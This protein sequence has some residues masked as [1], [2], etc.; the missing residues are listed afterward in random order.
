MD[1]VSYP[2]IP[3][4]PGAIWAEPWGRDKKYG[5]GRCLCVGDWE[6]SAVGYPDDLAEPG[7]IPIFGLA[8]QR[9][10]G[11]IDHPY[12]YMESNN[13]R[14]LT[15]ADADELIAVIGEIRDKLRRLS[16]SNSPG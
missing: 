4:P 16:D 7:H 12:I 13:S 5:P 9:P 6:V 1:T 11:E 2:D 14:P 8:F 10:S 3:I 15:L